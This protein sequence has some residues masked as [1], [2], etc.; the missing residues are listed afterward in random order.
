MKGDYNLTPEQ[1]EMRTRGLRILPRW[2]ASMYLRDRALAAKA[3]AE[4]SGPHAHPSRRPRR[5]GVNG[6]EQ[7]TARRK[8]LVNAHARWQLMD[9]HSMSQNELAR[10][11]GLSQGYLSQLTNGKR[12]PSPKTRRRMLQAFDVQFSD[13]FVVVR[14]DE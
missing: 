6:M 2:I 8:I 14:D 3:D 12:S 1:E 4:G 10:F 9:L 13:L 5:G 11:L 7:R